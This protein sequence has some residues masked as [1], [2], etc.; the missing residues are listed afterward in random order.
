MVTGPRIAA[1]D[2]WNVSF[3]TFFHWKS[4]LLADVVE[5]PVFSDALVRLPKQWVEGLVAVPERRRGVSR[6]GKGSD[7]NLS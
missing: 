2:I 3:N 4:N 1:I 5:A 6:D 7:V